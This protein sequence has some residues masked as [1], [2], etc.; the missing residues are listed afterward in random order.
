MLVERGLQEQLQELNQE[1]RKRRA[2]GPEKEML[3]RS[4]RER[5]G[6][7][8]ALQPMGEKEVKAWS[9][10]RAM[11]GV[12]GS[13]NFYGHGFPYVVYLFQ[14]LARSTRPAEDRCRVALSEVRSPMLP[15][16]RQLLA[17]SGREEVEAWESLRHRRLAE[18]EVEV[19]IEAVKAFRPFLVLFDGGLTRY[20]VQAGRRW[21]EYR[22]LALA[23]GVLTVGVIEETG[24]SLLS[25]TLG[26][27]LPETLRGEYDR[28]LL[29]G[30]LDPGECFRLREDILFKRGDFYTCFA[31]LSWH[32]QAVACDFFR[33]QVKEVPRLMNYLF[34]VTPQGG[35]GIPLWLDLVDR[36]ARI[37]G[38]DL[39][40]M[41]SA[42]V[43]T[44]IREI[45]LTPQRER[46]DF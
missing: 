16:D 9:G 12:D 34:T 3:R 22:R 24:T 25:D 2:A 18:M 41:L 23:E 45:F 29:F 21:E 27:G 13:V 7:F 46:R 40:M 6:R 20:A 11:V 1:L 33:E 36:E 31:R 17:S 30:L 38:R 10:G 42:C 14:A 39:E 35:R 32:P 28:V 19:A 15:G 4:M 43:E 5:L 37:S 8:A 26:E 44:E